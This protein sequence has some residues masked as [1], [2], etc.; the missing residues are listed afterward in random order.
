MMS[1]PVQRAFYEN[2]GDCPDKD[3]RLARLQEYCDEAVVT[4]NEKM[5]EIVPEDQMGWRSIVSFV[6]AARY[7]LKNEVWRQSS[8]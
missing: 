6:I 1:V 3:Y 4:T 5:M 2:L 8:G 7:R